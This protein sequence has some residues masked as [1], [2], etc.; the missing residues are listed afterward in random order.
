MLK[1]I[2]FYTYILQSLK[3]HKFYIGHTSRDPYFRLKE[4]NSKKVTSTKHRV[5]FELIHSEECTTRREAI[6]KEKKFKN[7]KRGEWRS[8]ASAPEWGSGGQRFESA[9]PD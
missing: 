5:P 8:L 2:R 4:H 6:E 7:R 1:R 9:L 3:D